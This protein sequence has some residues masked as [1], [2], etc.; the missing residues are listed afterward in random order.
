M[1]LKPLETVA[2]FNLIKN[3]YCVDCH[4]SA[5]RYAGQSGIG[6]FPT[7]WP[8]ASRSPRA[9]SW[10]R[11]RRRPPPPSSN[12][13]MTSTPS[14]S[15]SI[16]ESDQRSGTAG[17]QRYLGAE[18]RPRPGRLADVAQQPGGLQ[19]ASRH[20]RPPT[21]VENVPLA[22][23]PQPIPL[24]SFSAPIAVQRMSCFGAGT[25]V[26]TLTG[27]EPIESLKV[28]DQVLTQS[29]Q[30]RR[31]G[32]QADPRRAPQPAQQDLSR[33]SSARRR[34]SA[35]ISTGSGRPVRAG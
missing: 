4:D 23:Q 13:K 1:H 5:E 24:G 9:A 29:I 32:V 17:L 22:Y 12:C 28:G 2:E 30:D 26:R 35:A 6:T 20:P 25:M 33:S 16:L 34:S 10:S 18:P 15:T 21:V 11:P 19:L 31:P 7:P 14:T 27:L 3:P 8:E